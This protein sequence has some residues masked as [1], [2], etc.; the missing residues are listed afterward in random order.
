MRMRVA[1]AALVLL[2]VAL[3]ALVTMPLQSRAAAASDQYRQAR[4]QRRA[5]RTRL[6]ELERRESARS[7]AEA[8]F[9]AARSAPGGGVRD[10]RRKV[11]DLVSRSRVSGVRLAVRPARPPASA[12]VGLAA[13]GSFDDVLRLTGELSRPG[14]GL[15]LERVRLAPRGAARVVLDVQASGLGAA[16]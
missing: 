4:D 12:S 16:P 6:A 7:R 11:V 15:I 8:A 13:E 2:A 1:A 9:A 3:H 5:A 14:N 10:V